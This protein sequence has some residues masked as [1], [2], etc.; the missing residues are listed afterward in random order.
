MQAAA[1]LFVERGFEGVSM[2]DIAQALGVS[3]PT[4]YTY[5]PSP[6]SILDALLAEEGAK[7]LTD[8]ANDK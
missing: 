4:V 1:L 3:R 7:P 8:A 5:F 6:E 2:A